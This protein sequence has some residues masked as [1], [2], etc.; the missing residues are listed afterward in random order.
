MICEV[1]VET[2]G[3][4]ISSQC[5]L[6]SGGDMS[7]VRDGLFAKLLVVRRHTSLMAKGELA[8]TFPSKKHGQWVIF[9]PDILPFC[10][11]IISAYICYRLMAFEQ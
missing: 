8:K 7:A 6:M 3:N 5:S 4:V 1:S 11:H 10:T 9:S 2:M